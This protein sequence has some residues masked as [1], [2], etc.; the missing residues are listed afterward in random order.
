AL[1][2]RAS[3]V[4]GQRYGD[5]GLVYSNARGTNE[6]SPY[7]STGS[8]DVEGH[9]LLR[10]ITWMC[11]PP[12][13]GVAGTCDACDVTAAAKWMVPKPSMGLLAVGAACL[14]GRR[15]RRLSREGSAC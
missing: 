13:R 14:L 7:S 10:A 4:L 5:T 3:D 9:N 8:D 6:A 2:D 15:I 11:D 1:Q 12:P